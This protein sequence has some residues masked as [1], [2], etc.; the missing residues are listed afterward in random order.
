MK[1]LYYFLADNL[2]YIALVLVLGLIPDLLLRGIIP[3]IHAGVIAFVV[4]VLLTGTA[5][6]LD[7]QDEEPEPYCNYCA[8]K[9]GLPNPNLFD[10][11]VIHD[12]AIWMVGPDGGWV[13][14]DI[15]YC[16]MCGRKLEDDYVQR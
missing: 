15:D 5:L 8:Q 7:E 9:S 3:A 12:H 11:F 13:G 2:P 6:K 16:P 14:T 4:I 10:G 1:R